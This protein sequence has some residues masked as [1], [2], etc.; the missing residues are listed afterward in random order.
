VRVSL[1]LSPTRDCEARHQVEETHMPHVQYKDSD[2]CVLTRRVVV[3][4]L[5]MFS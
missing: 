3:R 4:S 1:R 2:G 5:S